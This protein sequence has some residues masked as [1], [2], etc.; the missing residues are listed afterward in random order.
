[1]NEKVN[2]PAH[3]GGED[4]PFEVI[5]VLE[6]WLTPEEFVGFCRGNSIKYTARARA[7]GGAEDIAK[8]AWYDA[9]LVEFCRSRPDLFAKVTGA[10]ARQLQQSMERNARMVNRLKQLQ[11]QCG[12]FEPRYSVIGD[13]AAILRD[14]DF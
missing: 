8:A 2:H 4:N 7:K 12:D 3:Y 9:R 11:A 13:I 10:V 6:A 1:M 14:E 5:K